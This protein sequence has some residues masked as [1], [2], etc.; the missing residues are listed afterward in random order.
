MA[1][2]ARQILAQRGARTNG[3][4]SNETTRPIG[5]LAILLKPSAFYTTNMNRQKMKRILSAM[6][7]IVASLSFSQGSFSATFVVNSTADD[8][9]VAFDNQCTTANNECTLRAAI[10][11]ANRNVGRDVIEFSNIATTITVHTPLPVIVHPVDLLGASVNNCPAWSRKRISS[12][13]T[14]PA[15]AHGIVL[16]PGSDGSVIHGI[17]ITGF[18]GDGIR[19]LGNSNSVRCSNIGISNAPIRAEGNG[20]TGIYIRGNNN[21]IGTPNGRNFIG[22][23]GASGIVIEG[24]SNNNLRNNTIGVGRNST[25]LG[26]MG[27]G[28]FI[29]QGQGN[30]I[31]NGSAEGRNFISANDGHGIHLNATDFTRVAGNYIGTNE[32]GIISDPKLGNAKNGIQI[33]SS[34]RSS[35]G[36]STAGRRN[37]I[38]GNRKNGIAIF[39]E[40]TDNSIRNNSIGVDLN[41]ASAG[42]SR[43]GISIEGAAVTETIVKNN[44]IANNQL[45]I[46]ITDGASRNKFS[47]NTL[48]NNNELGIDLGGDGPDNND[49][50]DQDTGTNLRLNYPVIVSATNSGNIVGALDSTSGT[51]TVEFYHNE[52]CDPSN[53]GEGKHFL[54]ATSVVVNDQDPS[55]FSIQFTPFSSGYVT[56]LTID[57]Q[58]NTSEF[59]RCK[60]VEIRTIEIVVNSVGD[61]GDVDL[62]D[63]VCHTVD[64]KDECTLRAAIEQA[65][66]IS[67]PVSIT[68][69]SREPGIFAINPQVALPSITGPTIIDGLGNGLGGMCSDSLDAPHELRVA[70]DGSGT[71]IENGLHFAAGSNSSAV[72]GLMIGGFTKNG[73]RIESNNNSIT[74]S[75]IGYGETPA[76]MMSGNGEWGISISGSNNKIGGLDNEYR[77]VISGNGTSAVGNAVQFTGG[78]SITSA[79]NTSVLRNLIGTERV[80]GF[81]KPNHGVGLYLT[82]S[83]YSRIVGNTIGGNSYDGI[84]LAIN[85]DEYTEIRG[86]MIGQG[87]EGKQLGNG[88]YGVYANNSRFEI[89]GSSP[90]HGN[91]INNNAEEGI[92]I[93][94]GLLGSQPEIYNIQ[95]NIIGGELDNSNANNGGVHVVGVVPVTIYDN[96]FRINGPNP[97]ISITC[98]QGVDCS[99]QTQDNV[100]TRVERNTVSYRSGA[101]SLLLK[102][103]SNTLVKDNLLLGFDNNSHVVVEGFDDTP[104]SANVIRNNTIGNDETQ[105]AGSGGS[106]AGLVI[107]SGAE[108]ITLEGNRLTS[109]G[110]PII[111]VETD[112]NTISDNVIGRPGGGAVVGL[113]IRGGNNNTVTGNTIGHNL[114]GVKLQN[115]DSNQFHGNGIGTSLD[116]AQ[117]LGNSS[118][119]VDIGNGSNNNQIGGDAA[120]LYNQ[121]RNN[122]GVGI[123]VADNDIGISQGNSMF[124]NEISDN[125]QL[126]I[127]LAHDD[128]TPNDIASCD[129]DEGQ[130]K[131]QNFPTLNGISSAGNILG[132]LNSRPSRNYRIDVFTSENCDS[133]GYGEGSQYFGSTIVQLGISGSDSFAVSPANDNTPL[134]HYTAIAT[135]LATNNSSEF[136][137]CY[138]IGTTVDDTGQSSSCGAFN[139]L[140]KDGSS[141]QSGSGVVVGAVTGTLDEDVRIS[142]LIAAEP[143]PAYDDFAVRVSDYYQLSAEADKL[144]PLD[145][146]FL[147]GVPKPDGVASDNLAI[148]IL[149]DNSDNESKPGLGLAWEFAPASYDADDNLLTFTYSQL[150]TSN[151][152]FTVVQAP[153]FNSMQASEDFDVENQA[154]KE[155]SDIDFRIGCSGAGCNNATRTQEF[156]SELQSAYVTF[157]SVHGFNPPYLKNFTAYWDGEFNNPIL[158]KTTTYRGIWLYHPSHPRCN[159][160]GIPPGVVIKGYYDEDIPSLSIC[161]E[162]LASAQQSIWHEFFH[163]IQASYPELLGDWNNNKNRILWV[164]EGTANVASV[165]QTDI[166]TRGTKKG[167]AVIKGERRVTDKLT[168]PLNSIPY[169]TEEFW[170]YY[171]S[172]GGHQLNQLETIFVEGADVADVDNALNHQLSSIYWSWVKNQAHEHHNL[173]D[174]AF[175]GTDL[176]TTI[177]KTIDPNP[178]N[179]IPIQHTQNQYITPDLQLD[180]LDTAVVKF[181]VSTINPDREAVVR[182]E[183]VSGGE[184]T[185]YKVYDSETDGADDTCEAIQDGQR[186]V[187]NLR[188]KQVITV[189]VA[190]TDLTNPLT[191]KVIVDIQTSDAP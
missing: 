147:I 131:K 188:T 153:S 26:N 97:H 28:I 112:G 166:H 8:T 38:V 157:V 175:N 41:N 167:N 59:S 61:E 54:G 115:A 55:E 16:A 173:T 84:H 50:A 64:D 90:E 178:L 141:A 10:E 132:M 133:S 4:S 125:G 96:E 113:H 162:D 187:I 86:N 47:E 130:N 11:E 56:A 52:S 136:S 2:V 149:S 104:S 19:I 190:N 89:G 183:N 36:G 92:F 176:C 17:S 161:S 128:V 67:A 83:G 40:S 27:H 151:L 101:K 185:H 51:Y 73:I 160:P 32:D 74:C 152:V 9:D 107:A 163:A 98:D 45:G 118:H 79:H 105:T 35:I 180:P 49:K 137:A 69:D 99:L 122:G 65:N 135:D 143:T 1:A 145:K 68:F 182:A 186:T 7:L 181:E 87:G 174:G 58:G 148:A 63:G 80:V 189:I 142:A 33:E 53:H 103:A 57:S 164:L 6:L 46:I 165:S 88:R 106:V 123:L 12:A 43:S 144:A 82:G 120:L 134:T 126:G 42:N 179:A 81:S 159:P 5:K 121:I 177:A 94:S 29:K 155:A 154:R 124:A 30:R 156:A 3:S 91:V 168:S 116:G 138:S 85:I 25:I 158:N 140:L 78:I 15:G 13:D 129:S 75:F 48:F 108:S 172:D 109:Q 117:D 76:R 110:G 14:M 44:V 184:A 77:N 102:G 70:I 24:G 191:T 171:L 60:E 72:L 93:D 62:G 18:P 71:D 20:E 66:A 111:L 127:D 114:V 169:K 150:R 39:G 31:G 100:N 170:F 22:A 139:D 37:L 34:T 23:N 21:L 119:G 146:P 95:H